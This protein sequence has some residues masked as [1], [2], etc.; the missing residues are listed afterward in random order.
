[1]KSSRSRTRP[2]RGKSS[3]V[4]GAWKSRRFR[5]RGFTSPEQ[6]RGNE[7]SRHL[8]T[9]GELGKFWQVGSN[10]GPNNYGQLGEASSGKWATTSNPNN[11]RPFYHDTSESSIVQPLFGKLAVHF[12]A[13]VLQ[14]A[15]GDNIMRTRA[16]CSCSCCRSHV[17][18]FTSHVNKGHSF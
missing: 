6:G 13:P 3:Q 5:S 12:G 4:G 11:C 9:Q 18:A 2:R 10:G 1:M 15:L 17:L 8:Q 7:Q 16:A 14:L